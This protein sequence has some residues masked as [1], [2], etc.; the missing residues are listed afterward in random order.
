MAKSETSRTIPLDPRRQSLDSLGYGNRPLIA[1]AA[2]T[3]EPR[4]ARQRKRAA[5]CGLG[6]IIAETHQMKVASTYPMETRE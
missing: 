4:K 1:G 6:D 5:G 3:A 2:I